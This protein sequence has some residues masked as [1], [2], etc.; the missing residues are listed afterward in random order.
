MS[1]KNFQVDTLVQKEMHRLKKFAQCKVTIAY[2]KS[3]CKEFIIIQ[4]L[5]TR[6][7]KLHFQY[8]LND[9]DLLASHILC[10]NETKIQ[11]IQTHQKIYNI[12]LNK[13]KILSCYEQHGT[14]IFYNTN[15]FLSHTFSKTNSSIGFLIA[16]FNENT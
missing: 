16:L 13:L 4:S 15:M 11:N 8:I 6:S 14:L 12:I 5:I 9:L 10:L 7:L 2:L 3:Y 1:N